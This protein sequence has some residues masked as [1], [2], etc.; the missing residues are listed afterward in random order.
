[1]KLKLQ[2]QNNDERQSILKTHSDKYLIEEQN[3]KEG[4]FLIFSDEAPLPSLEVQVSDLR[5]DN[6]VLMDA[7]ATTFE[8]IL[9]LREEINVL[10]G[11]G[12]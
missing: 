12:V 5:Q 4:N 1:M 11:G 10:N 7:L 2:Y 9:M 6:V 3:I 8:E